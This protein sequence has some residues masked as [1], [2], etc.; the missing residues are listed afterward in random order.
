MRAP[1]TL[2]SHHPTDQHPHTHCGST[3]LLW[4][5]K[6]LHH[7]KKPSNDDSPALGAQDLKQRGLWGFEALIF[8]L[9]GAANT[10]KQRFQPG[11]KIP[12][13]C[14]MYFVHPQNL[15]FWSDS[16]V[17]KRVVGR[18]SHLDD[19]RQV[20]NPRSFV[21][22]FPRICPTQSVHVPSK[23]V[24]RPLFTPQKPSSGGTWTLWASY[25]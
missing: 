2:S 24:L 15:Q 10:N 13:W 5:H 20:V 7:P 16:L 22:P 14:E 21:R 6:I 17:S 19:H 18:V 23:E 12:K 1:L 25:I 4:I 9:L 11:F 3:H 8:C